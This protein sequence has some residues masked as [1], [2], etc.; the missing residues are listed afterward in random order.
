MY[1]DGCAAFGEEF[2]GGEAE[3]RTAAQ[4]EGDFAAKFLF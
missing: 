4:D 3:T 1:G 2:G